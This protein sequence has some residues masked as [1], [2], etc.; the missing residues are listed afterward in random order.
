ML[1]VLGNVLKYKNSQLFVSIKLLYILG[2]VNAFENLFV[3]IR[4]VS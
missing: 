4:N 3:G 2:R 1:L